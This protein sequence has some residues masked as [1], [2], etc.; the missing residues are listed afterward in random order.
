MSTPRKSIYR[1]HTIE[2]SGDNFRVRDPHGSYWTEVAVTREWAK[3]WID[4]A[5]AY[6]RKR[7]GISLNPGCH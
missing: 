2:P 1:E 4:R 5:L 3:R 6:D 7:D